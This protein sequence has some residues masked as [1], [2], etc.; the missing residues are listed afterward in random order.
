M[1]GQKKWLLTALKGISPAQW[2]FI[3]FG[4]I[5]VLFVY[6]MV[7][8]QKNSARGNFKQKD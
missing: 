8:H 3:G 7:K 1:N 5:T 2:F 6:L 4:A